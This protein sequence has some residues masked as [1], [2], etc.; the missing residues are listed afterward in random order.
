MNEPPRSLAE[1]VQW[2]RVSGILAAGIDTADSA[3]R[4]QRAAA[5]QLDAAQYSLDRM[6]AELVAVM[7]AAGRA[8][9]IDPQPQPAVAVEVQEPEILAA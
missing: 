9:T 5:D 7:P 4:H 8:A 6:L 3:C 1:D 2:S